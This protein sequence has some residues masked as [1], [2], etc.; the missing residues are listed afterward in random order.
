MNGGLKVLCTEHCGSQS[1][2]ESISL[3]C[4]WIIGE[5]HVL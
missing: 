4:I 1:V 2:N 3:N 5:L